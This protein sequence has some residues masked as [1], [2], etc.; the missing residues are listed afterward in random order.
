M[1]LYSGLHAVNTAAAQGHKQIVCLLLYRGSH[2]HLSEG[3][4]LSPIKHAATNGHQKKLR[5]YF[6][7]ARTLTMQLSL[8]Q[9]VARLIY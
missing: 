7:F 3:L 4:G 9:A 2:V 5:Y 8:L 6:N 1:V